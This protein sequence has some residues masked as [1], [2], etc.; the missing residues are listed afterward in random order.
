MP[1]DFFVF[2]C[3]W[4]INQIELALESCCLAIGLVIKSYRISHRKSLFSHRISYSKKVPKEC[5]DNWRGQKYMI[6]TDI[7]LKEK[8]MQMLELQ[9]AT[10]CGQQGRISRPVRAILSGRL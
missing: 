3:V 2:S 9:T 6:Y 1:G 8:I 7:Q 4:T 5:A 10:F